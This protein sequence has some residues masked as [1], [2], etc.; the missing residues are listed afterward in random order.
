MACNYIFIL[1]L[2]AHANAKPIMTILFDYILKYLNFFEQITFG[3]LTSY[4]TVE[5]SYRR[6]QT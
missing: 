5:F 6:Q 4:S 2:G 3:S 1:A